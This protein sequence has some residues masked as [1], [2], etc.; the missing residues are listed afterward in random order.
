MLAP[1]TP[2]FDCS[3]GFVES[4]A[5]LVAEQT[6]S[7]VRLIAPLVTLT[8]PEIVGRARAL[9]VSLPDTYSCQEGTVLLRPCGKCQLVLRRKAIGC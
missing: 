7:R 3:A 6:D 5:R 1:N 2:F 9:E 4:M 8:K